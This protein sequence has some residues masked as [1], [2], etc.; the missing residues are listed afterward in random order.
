LIIDPAWS[1]EGLFAFLEGLQRLRAVGDP[2]RL[3]LPTI[4]TRHRG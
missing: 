2:T 3:A 1:N 4:E